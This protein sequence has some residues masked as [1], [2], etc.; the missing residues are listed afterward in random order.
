MNGLQMLRVESAFRAISFCDF[1]HPECCR[2]IFFDAQFLM[3]LDSQFVAQH[4]PAVGI[5]RYVRIGIGA[6]GLRFS[7]GEESG[8]RAF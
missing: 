8:R 6:C 5:V 4:V 2:A 3:G 1:S 7:H